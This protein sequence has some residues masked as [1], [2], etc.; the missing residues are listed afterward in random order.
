MFWVKFLARLLYS[1]NSLQAKLF[2]LISADVNKALLRNTDIFCKFRNCIFSVFY[3][4][5]QQN[6]PIL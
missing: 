1:Y 5:S 3:K 6:V 2:P 4:H